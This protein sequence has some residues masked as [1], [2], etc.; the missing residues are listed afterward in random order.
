MDTKEIKPLSPEGFRNLV[1]NKEFQKSTFYQADFHQFHIHQ[2]EE[3]R[4]YLTTDGVVHRKTIPDLM[5]LTQG[6]SVRSVGLQKFEIKAPCFFFLPELSMV[7]NHF[8]SEDA[9][10]YYCHF[11]PSFLQK[12]YGSN[13]LWNQILLFNWKN[14]PIVPIEK[15]DLPFYE[16]LFQRL[17]TDYLGNNRY[18]QTLIAQELMTLLFRIQSQFSL[19]DELKSSHT[20]V[21]MKFMKMVSSQFPAIFTVEGFASELN[22]SA[23][24]LNR[25]VKAETAKTASSFIK[26]MTLSHAKIMLQQPDRPSV[27]EIADTLHFSTP[28]HFARFFKAQT[29]LTPKAYQEA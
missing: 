22:V 29:G 9:T 17:L 5:L 27:S 3:A 11:S 21:V 18:C 6:K 26:E 4:Q 16:V 2:L 19:I 8:L 24:H 10:G 20:S 15:N 14:Y 12:Q 13:Y 1:V 23:N 7:A 25:L 28:S